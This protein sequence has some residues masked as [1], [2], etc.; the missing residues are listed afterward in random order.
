MDHPRGL[1]VKD[2]LRVVGASARPVGASVVGH[3]RVALSAVAA[4]ALFVGGASAL[5]TSPAFAT[6]APR[7]TVSQNVEPPFGRSLEGRMAAL[8]ADIN[9]GPFTSAARL[10]FPESAYVAMKTGRIPS[11]AT[12]YRDRLAAFYRLDLLAYRDY[13]RADG[14]AT[15][16]GINASATDA[17]WIRPGWC[18]NSIGYWHVAG[19][20]LVY[21]QG[22]V[23]RSVGVASLISWRGVWY[24]V[25]LGPN[26]RPR[27][28]G[29]V[30]SPAQGRGIAGPAGGC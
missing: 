15:F 21:R 5:A 4:M 22:R 14:P 30:D 23:V 1:V 18:E 13:I 11:P 16:L 10:Y 6:R 2:V 9:R 17:Q 29:T 3:L 12:D 27:D 8:F 7:A 20:R 24:V 26:P 25:H 19:V 28:V